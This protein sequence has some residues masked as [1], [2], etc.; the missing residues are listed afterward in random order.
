MRIAFRANLRFARARPPLPGARPPSA[1]SWFLGAAAAVGLAGACA[2]PDP[3]A[4]LT[5]AA[6]AI[7]Q[8]ERVSYDFNYEESG[9]GQAE[10]RGWVRLVPQAAQALPPLFSARIQPSPLWDGVSPHWGPPGEPVLL[11]SGG[12]EEVAVMDYATSQMRFGSLDGAGLHLAHFSLFGVVFE[13]A[14][15][16]P[17][18]RELGSELSYAGRGSVR[19]VATDI[20][21][22]VQSGGGELLWHIGADDNLPRGYQWTGPDGE[23]V[24]LTIENLDPLRIVQSQELGLVPPE[25]F[26]VIRED[27]RLFGVGHP[28]P[29]LSGASPDEA[30]N[31]DGGGPM[32]VEFGASWCGPCRDLETA[33]GEAGGELAS[34]GASAHG[35]RVWEP[36]ATA[37]GETPAEAPYQVTRRAEAAALDYRVSEIPAVFVIDGEGVLRLALNPVSGQVDEA[38]SAVLGSLRALQELNQATP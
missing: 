33:L 8:L 28:A 1:R 34:L 38:V 9:R 31:A 2:S 26:A 20:I 11:V 16:D 10:Y 5:A 13:F 23:T 24:R 12:S 15:L 18:A 35:L 25:R 21:R 4:R 32:I 37:D 7:G 36:A 17:F 3:A 14:G 19:G 30:G 6:D 22:S 27:E 29:P